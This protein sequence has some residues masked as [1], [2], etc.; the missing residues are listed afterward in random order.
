MTI[1]INW[2]DHVAYIV[3]VGW[4]VWKVPIIEGENKDELIMF[5]KYLCLPGN[6][7]V[8]LG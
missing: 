7:K 2:K 3:G 6:V 8:Y 1:C 4:L 5:K